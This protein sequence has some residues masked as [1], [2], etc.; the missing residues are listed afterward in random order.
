MAHAP[1]FLF[2]PVWVNNCAPRH[3]VTRWLSAFSAISVI[4]QIIGYL[5]SGLIVWQLG[6]SWRLA[7]LTVAIVITV[8]GVALSLCLSS[9]VFTFTSSKESQTSSDPESG[10]GTAGQPHMFSLLSELLS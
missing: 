1:G 5:V 10:H 2:F 8:C 6:L 4:G 9:Q 7:M 3:L